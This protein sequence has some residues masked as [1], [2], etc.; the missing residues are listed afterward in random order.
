VVGPT[1]FLAAGFGGIVFAEAFL[2][3]PE[4][5]AKPLIIGIE[6]ALTVSIAAALG[7]LVAGWPSREAPR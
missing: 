7:M 3:Y 6:A 2:A 1:L 4:G 5:W